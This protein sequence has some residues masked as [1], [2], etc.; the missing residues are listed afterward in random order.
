M[1]TAAFLLA[2]AAV[3]L[4]AAG[5]VAEEPAGE[6][7][8]VLADLELGAHWAGPEVTLEE[9]RGKVVLFVLWGS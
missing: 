8:A 4:A 3:C 2:A 9:L 6:S 7:S 1:R 5:A